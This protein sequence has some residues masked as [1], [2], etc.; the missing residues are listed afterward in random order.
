MSDSSGN[1]IGRGVGP[2]RRRFQKTTFGSPFLQAEMI[3]LLSSVVEM[4]GLA[5]HR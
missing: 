3:L 1:P 5:L 4:Q 2:S